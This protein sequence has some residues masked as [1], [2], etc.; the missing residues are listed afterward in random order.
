MQPGLQEHAAAGAAPLAQHPTGA[1]A[2]QQERGVAMAGPTAEQGA[3][4]MPA[5]Q[6]PTV[7]TAAAAAAVTAAAAAPTAALAAPTSA[8]PARGAPDTAP[9]CT[10]PLQQLIAEQQQQQHAAAAAAAAAAL[11]AQQQLQQQVQQQQFAAAGAAATPFLHPFAGAVPPALLPTLPLTQEQMWA[12]FTGGQ[13]QVA[14]DSAAMPAAA[15]MLLGAGA[16]ASLGGAHDVASVLA[17][18]PLAVQALPM[19][20]Q[21]PQP[22]HS[23]SAAAA[24]VAGASSAL[25]P[26]TGFQADALSRFSGNMDLDG[27]VASLL[28]RAG[29]GAAENDTALASDARFLHRLC[30]TDGGDA[31]AKKLVQEKS[32]RQ[33][34]SL[35]ERIT[36]RA[37]YARLGLPGP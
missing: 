32:A 23:A 6:L 37:T 3:Q 27:M 24:Q 14:L 20:P 35:L 18:M 21:P 9:A 31:C 10:N 25:T 34:A 28:D 19:V 36:A 17:R 1:P 4:V 8:P 11:E 12:C 16:M 5:Q 26:T 15:P 7:V 13:Q 29:S 2:G 30:S 22:L 33:L